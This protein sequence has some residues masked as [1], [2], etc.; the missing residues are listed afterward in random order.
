MRGLVVSFEH[1]GLV[2]MVM[3]EMPSTLGLMLSDGGGWI[4]RAEAG[5]C[6]ELRPEVRRIGLQPGLDFTYKTLGVQLLSP[7][8]AVGE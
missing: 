8:K 5:D 1:I 4:F 3:I 6:F 2:M 7:Q